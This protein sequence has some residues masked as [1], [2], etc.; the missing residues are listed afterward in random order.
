[1]HKHP[2]TGRFRLSMS[3]P[4]LLLSLTELFWILYPLFLRW[5]GGMTMGT[6]DFEW[7]FTLVFVI[8][9][10]A[11]YFF[12]CF[13]TFSL[14]FLGFLAVCVFQHALPLA[15]DLPFEQRYA[16]LFFQPHSF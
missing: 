1:M 9:I 7:I 4:E 13:S 3:T 11:L 5:V 10:Y 2:D 12:F 16:R 14:Y 15:S 6:F 8:F